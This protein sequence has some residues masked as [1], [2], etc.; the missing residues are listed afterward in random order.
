VH[1]LL[2]G[3]LL[4]HKEVAIPSGSVSGFRGGIHLNITSQQV[5]D[6][7]HADIDHPTG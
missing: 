7:A 4:G 2:K 5:R 3:H 1:V 6:L